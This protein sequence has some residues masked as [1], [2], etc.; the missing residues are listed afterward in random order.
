[1]ATCP[2]CG[3]PLRFRGASSIVAVCAYCKSTLV[4][5]GARLEDIGK[6]ADLLEDDSPIQLGTGGRYRGERF[7]VVGRIQYR[8]PAGL[9]SEWHALFDNG[10]SGWLSDASREYTMTFLAPPAPVPPH[11]SLRPGQALSLAGDRY[12]VADLESAEVIAGEGELPFRWQSGW[13]APVADLRGAGT[14]FATIDYSEDPP[15]VYLGEKLPFEA[16]GFDNLRDPDR[17]VEPGGRALA[18][19]CAGCGAPIEKSLATTKV[20]ACGSCGTVTDVSGTVGELVQRNEVNLAAFTPSI[21]LGTVLDWR[22]SRY[23]AVGCLRRAFPADGVTY[24]WTEYLLHD[25]E[26]GYLWISEYDGHFS[27]VRAAAD[28]PLPI[29]SSLRSVPR[30]RYLGREFTH[31]QHCDAAVSW[32]VGEFYWRVGLG[33]QARVDDYVAPPLILSSEAT[34]NEIT[35][36]LGEYVE[37]EALWKALGLKGKPPRRAGLAANQPSPHQGKPF[38][39][40][41]LCFAFLGVAALMQFGFSLLGSGSPPRAVS[42]VAAPGAVTRTVSPVLP[43]GGWL[44]GPV[45][46]HSHASS[47]NAHFDLDYQLVETSSGRAFHLV[48]QVGTRGLG[49]SRSGDTDDV[50]EIESLPRGSYVLTIDARAQVTPDPKAPRLA[51]DSV[52]GQVRLYRQAPGWSNFALLAGFLMLWPLVEWARARGFEQRRWAESDHPLTSSEDDDD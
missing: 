22:G 43:L 41:M 7:A 33:D 29:G 28:D 51:T 16:F 46:V 38:A 26:Q 39:L 18:F 32:L 40:W 25:V 20:V 50:A 34:D 23:E 42:F 21:P 48:R 11:E 37:P 35:W 30:V 27:L 31:F 8:Y 12:S 9:W 14:R 10:R 44:D 4:R 13:K 24:E 17:P 3:G 5:D 19:K 1:M 2:S 49:T 36:S 52:A 47:T 45:I 15:H 6:Q